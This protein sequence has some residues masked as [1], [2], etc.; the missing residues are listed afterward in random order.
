MFGFK[1]HKKQPP[2]FFSRHYSYSH[3]KSAQFTK[4]QFE[5]AAIWW[6]QFLPGVKKVSFEEINQHSKLEDV[7]MMSR[8]HDFQRANTDA[9]TKQ[10]LIAFIQILSQKIDTLTLENHGGDLSYLQIGDESSYNPPE[11]VEN[12]LKESSIK[13]SAFGLFPYKTAMKIYNNG[14]IQIG[15]QVFCTNPEIKHYGINTNFVHAP[16]VKIS[17][18][19]F[20]ALEIELDA[21]NGQLL[22][23]FINRLRKFEKKDVLSW[24]DDIH[25]PISH[26][27]TSISL[28]DFKG[29][30]EEFLQFSNEQWIH[31]LQDETEIHKYFHESMYIYYRKT[32]EEWM[33][34]TYFSIGSAVAEKIGDDYYQYTT[35]P[36]QALR[37]THKGTVGT[38]S[39]TCIAPNDLIIKT[40]MWNEVTIGYLRNSNDLFKIQLCDKNGQILRGVKTNDLLFATPITPKHRLF[41]QKPALVT[42]NESANFD[43]QNRM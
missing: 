36:V 2:L 10:Q 24:K 1:S 34:A 23:G 18:D 8:L 17:G 43:S 27:H 19:K 3:L 21:L 41:S 9:I 20:K 40:K 7:A 12:A 26:I 33:N 25:T 29:S 28:S 6:S 35:G 13:A 38:N 5:I 31:I 39:L 14:Q 11:I 22:T 42:E 32:R 16:W 15:N 37:A 30:E 4:K